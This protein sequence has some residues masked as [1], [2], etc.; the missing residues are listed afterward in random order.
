MPIGIHFYQRL[1]QTKL[2][3]EFFLFWGCSFAILF[4]HKSEKY[5]SK[6]LSVNKNKGVR[7]GNY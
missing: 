2:K 6:F 5:E 1:L 3:V 7:T 4:Y